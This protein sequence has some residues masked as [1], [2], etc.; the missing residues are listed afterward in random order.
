M[1][2]FLINMP[3]LYERFVAAWLRENLPPK[4]VLRAQENVRIGSSGAITFDIDLVLE[5]AKTNSVR[6]I[7]DTKYKSPERP[8]SDDV[9]QVVA[10]ATA[11]GC[12][13][14]V[15]VYPIGL[16]DSLDEDVGEVRVRSLAFALEGSLDEAGRDFLRSLLGERFIGE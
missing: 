4:F 9:Q 10:Y 1:L 14:A 2:P 11:K 8:S 13:D 3:L 16:R 12:R 7:L 6:A 5:D 15:L